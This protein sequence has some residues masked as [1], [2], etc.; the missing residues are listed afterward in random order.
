MSTLQVSV[1]GH[2][3]DRARLMGLFEEVGEYGGSPLYVCKWTGDPDKPTYFMFRATSDG[4]WRIV[5]EEQY[6]SMNLGFIRSNQSDAEVPFAPGVTWDADGLVV[7]VGDEAWFHFAA[8]HLPASQ[9][10]SFAVYDPTQDPTSDSFTAITD[11]DAATL[12]TLPDGN[13]EDGADGDNVAQAFANGADGD[14]EAI[15]DGA[16]EGSAGATDVDGVKSA[17][18]EI[19]PALKATVTMAV[20]HDHSAA[21]TADHA[22]VLPTSA[23]PTDAALD[24]ASRD[25]IDADTDSLGNTSDADSAS[26]DSFAMALKLA[27]KPHASALEQPSIGSADQR[28]LEAANAATAGAIRMQSWEPRQG[29]L[30]SGHPDINV[31]K[32]VPRSEWAFSSVQLESF[33]DPHVFEVGSAEESARGPAVDTAARSGASAFSLDDA[34]STVSQGTHGVNHPQGLWMKDDEPVVDG[35]ESILGRPKSGEASATHLEVPV[36]AHEPLVMTGM[37]L[38]KLLLV[39]GGGGGDH[40]D[41]G[42]RDNTG[43]LGRR[44][45][46]GGPVPRRRRARVGVCQLPGAGQPDPLY[47][48]RARA[49][50]RPDRGGPVAVLRADQHRHVSGV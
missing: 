1:T 15:S 12:P 19:N 42:G 44:G 35:A 10:A 50:R 38:D 7:S 3:G 31:V 21:T 37:E 47:H 33:P 13:D 27:S 9:E 8:I 43:R 23:D 36:L 4:A 29:H 16:G 41:N 30:L 25:T 49:D 14:A 46:R 2:L 22:P 26:V 32:W 17:L 28:M 48:Q 24:H 11:D 34:G 5:D 39:R 6:I 45:H 20:H 18:I 40:S